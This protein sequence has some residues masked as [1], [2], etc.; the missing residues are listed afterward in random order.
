MFIARTFL[1]GVADGL[2]DSVLRWRPLLSGRS[3]RLIRTMGA[4]ARDDR[5][6]RIAATEREP[7]PRR[8]TRSS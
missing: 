4:P 1:P 6:E 2:G 7:S 8:G 5:V 3:A